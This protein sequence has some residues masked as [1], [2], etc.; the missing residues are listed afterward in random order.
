MLTVVWV[1]RNKRKKILHIYEKNSLQ[2]NCLALPQ[3]VER[4]TKSFVSFSEF[5]N[6]ITILFVS[7]PPAFLYKIRTI[8]HNLNQSRVIYWGVLTGNPLEEIGNF[9]LFT[10][11]M[12]A[13]IT[14]G[15]YIFYPLFILK[16][17]LYYRQFMY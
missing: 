5:K 7:L 15:L 12:G 10:Y 17:G 2:I 14:C 8:W 9:N 11:C 6:W 16:S 4:A 13:N 3:R 1:C